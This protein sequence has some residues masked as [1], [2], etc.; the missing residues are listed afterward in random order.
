LNDDEVEKNG[1]TESVPSPAPARPAI[2][3]GRWVWPFIGIAF[4]AVILLGWLA[5]FVQQQLEPAQ[6]LNLDELQA[7][8]KLWDAKKPK[9]YQM[10]YTV[11]RGGVRGKDQ[12][13][14]EVKGNHVRSVLMNGNERLPPDKLDYHSMDALFND[15]ERFLHRDAQPGSPKTFCRGYFDT[16]DGH[17]QKFIRR[18][19]GGTESVE[20]KVEEF[21]PGGRKAD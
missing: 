11:Q 15:I 19:V 16:E 8:R 12:Y 6:Q 17:L 21:R 18:V 14:V 4:I 13:F 5:L 3:R 1:P 7:A 9:D 10:L 20:I 2:P